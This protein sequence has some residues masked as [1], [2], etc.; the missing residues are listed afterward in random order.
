[1]SSDIISVLRFSVS[2]LKM[3]SMKHRK[4]R[5]QKHSRTDYLTFTLPSMFF[6]LDVLGHEELFF[7]SKAN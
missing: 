4:H 2:H 6:T 3:L 7:F 5:L 1:M